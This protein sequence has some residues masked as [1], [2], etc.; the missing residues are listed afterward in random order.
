MHDTKCKMKRIHLLVFNSHLTVVRGFKHFR[1]LILEF[2]LFLDPKS[3]IQNQNLV[4][5]NPKCEGQKPR[6][7]IKRFPD[8]CSL[9]SVFTLLPQLSHQR[10]CLV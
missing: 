3:K 1:I 9:N 6:S 10:A 8:P 4:L 7:K 5:R 2:G